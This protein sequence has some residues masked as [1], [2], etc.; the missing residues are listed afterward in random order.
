MGSEG[1]KQLRYW[2]IK[3]NPHDND[4]DSLL[5][6]RTSSRWHTGRAPKAWAAGDRIFC[7]EST[8][9]LRIVG[10]G[11]LAE[12]DCGVDEYGHKLFKVEY[13][14]GRLEQ[15]VH[16]SELRRVPIL[17]Q[18]SFLKSGPAT[19]L[20]P[21]TPEQA[22]IL[23]QVVFSRNRS[24]QRA[25]PDVTVN[26]FAGLVADVDEEACSIEGASRILQHVVRER[27][28]DLVTR[29]RL[30]TLAEKGALRCEVCHF[31]FA[32]V[33]GELG[34]D[35]CEVHHRIPLATRD[36]PSET[37]L[38]DLAVVC[39]NCHRM[40]HRKETITVE[41]LRRRMKEVGSRRG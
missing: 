24:L 38:E 8:P 2:V 22:E 39:S 35:F 29:K 21:Q 15:M 13:L 4:W 31:D 17:G 40:L 23:I 27:R 25:W 41:L 7:W 12:V 3:G 10:I 32:A 36:W 18:A 34:K 9:K 6:P 5:R 1:A 11:R 30:R 28:S 33:Y 16:M 14:S 20:F 37:N 26:A 19:T